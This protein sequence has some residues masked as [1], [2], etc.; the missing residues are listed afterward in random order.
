MK[1]KK[2]I[3]SIT[4]ELM[5]KLERGKKGDV[6]PKFFHIIIYIIDEILAL[7]DHSQFI[8]PKEKI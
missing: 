2:E 7:E 8:P 3:F 6:F 4:Y 5:A 1:K